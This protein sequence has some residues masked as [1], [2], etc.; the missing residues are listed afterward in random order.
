MPIG[1]LLDLHP[2]AP[3]ALSSP[4][5]ARPRVPVNLGMTGSAR[6]FVVGGKLLEELLARKHPGEAY[7]DVPLGL[8]ARQA[9]EV[10]GQGQHR[11]RLSPEHRRA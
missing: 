5:F 11:H 2:I 6:P 3:G 10:L 9:N 4:W 8:E 1:V 7:F